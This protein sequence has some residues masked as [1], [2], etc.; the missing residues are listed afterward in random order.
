MAGFVGNHEVVAVINNYVPKEDVFFFTR[1]QPLESKA[2]LPLDM[3]KPL[4]S[5]VMSVR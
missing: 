2:K 4:H 3:A 1:K 5:L